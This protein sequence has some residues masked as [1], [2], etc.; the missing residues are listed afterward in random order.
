MLF[1]IQQFFA[2]FA[3]MGIS[4]AI[5]NAV[6]PQLAGEVVESTQNKIVDAIKMVSIRMG[7]FISFIWV[8]I[9]YA[10]VTPLVS[11]LLFTLLYVWVT[12]EKTMEPFDQD[13]VLV[14]LDDDM[15]LVEKESENWTF[16]DQENETDW[17][18]I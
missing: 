8:I 1:R 4:A 17:E 12:R 9:R 3:F 14:A 6:Y 2:G 10:P 5:L 7:W 11:F 15:V 18:L 13:V 16:V